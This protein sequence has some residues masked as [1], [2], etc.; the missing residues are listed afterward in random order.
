M[1]LPERNPPPP[2]TVREGKTTSGYMGGKY[3]YY[4]GVEYR[5]QPTKYEICNV[6]EGLMMEKCLKKDY[7]MNLLQQFNFL[8][9][10]NDMNYVFFQYAD[11]SLGCELH[12]NSL[13]SISCLVYKMSCF[14]LKAKDMFWKTSE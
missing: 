11:P 7:T 13:L 10:L 3:C 8:S 1:P 14:S 12:L 2:P 9:K 6:I 4:V 5:A